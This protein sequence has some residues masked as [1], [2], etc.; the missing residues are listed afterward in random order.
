[1]EIS[2]YLIKSTAILS[3]FFLIDYLFLRRETLFSNNRWFLTIGVFCAFILPFIE[4]THFTYV[5]S[6]PTATNF[7]EISFENLPQT[8]EEDFD[9]AQLLLSTYFVGI[10]L[11]LGR[12]LFQL[13]SLV[14]ILNKPKRK[15]TEGFYHI[16]LTEKLSPFSFFKYIAYYPASYTTEELALIIK[17][18]KIHGKQLHSIDVLIHQIMLIVFWFNPLAWLYQKRML[19]NLEFIADKEITRKNNIQQKNYELTLLKVST[20]YQ[21]P[22]LAN[23]F[24]QS[25]I[26]K[27]IVMLNKKQSK[28]YAFAKSILVLPLLAFFLWSFNVKEEVKVINTQKS[29]ITNDQ[30]SLKEKSPQNG[31]VSKSSITEVKV[32]YDKNTTKEALKKD[33]KFLKEQFDIDMKYSKLKFNNKNELTRLQLKIK[34]PGGFSG[35]V[36]SGSKNTAF[37]DVYFYRNFNDTENPFGIGLGTNTKDSIK[38]T[39][40]LYKKINENKVVVI[41]GIKK[42]LNQLLN[43]K[44]LVKSYS[45]KDGLVHINGEETHDYE[46]HQ[47]SNNKEKKEKKVFIYIDNEG[48]LSVIE[49]SATYSNFS[50]K[51]KATSE[52]ITQKQP[53]YYVNKEKITAKEMKLIDQNTIKSVNVL[54]DEKAIK[55]YGEEGKYGVIEITLKTKEEQLS[56]KNNS[57]VLN[58][59]KSFLD[60]NPLILLN[61]KETNRKTIESLDPNKIESVFIFKAEKGVEKYGEKAKNGAIIITTK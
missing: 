40:D 49:A 44:Y 3:L 1:M 24:Y 18:E 27:R 56:S 10:I 39:N 28:K 5:E 36:Y 32:T 43:S 48:K 51:N 46:S 23:Q 61:D 25:L 17:H 47:K 19:E 11:M 35:E 9:W 59:Y 41:N 45:I 42:N 38:I 22:S 30:I 55:K 29:T 21:A 6:L 15:D 12:F 14:K 50:N 60:K 26:K 34:T 54:K 53:L 52:S 33:K 31:I 7:E 16:E 13:L 4:Y 2:T 8:I 37:K 57:E 58:D 20:N